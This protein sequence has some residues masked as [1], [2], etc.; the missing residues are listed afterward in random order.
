V[1]AMATPAAHVASRSVLRG[2]NRC[3]NRDFRKF[4]CLNVRGP[5]MM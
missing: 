2:E 5:I 1:C 3:L 4:D